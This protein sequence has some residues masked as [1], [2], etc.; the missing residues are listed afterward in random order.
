MLAWH[1]F[2]L[3]LVPFPGSR[4]LKRE[5]PAPYGS[6]PLQ[7]RALLTGH[8][9][10]FQNGIKAELDRGLRDH[11]GQPFYFTDEGTCVEFLPKVTQQVYGRVETITRFPN[12]QSR[13]LA[14]L[15]E[16]Y[17]VPQTCHCFLKSFSPFLYFYW[18][19]SCVHNTL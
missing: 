18:I 15:F 7:T 4:I 14:N 6:P 16:G 17:S 19:S 5:N 10:L 12:F 11:I 8:F 2:L 3:F 13:M 9:H 1:H